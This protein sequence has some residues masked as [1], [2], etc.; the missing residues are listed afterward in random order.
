[1]HFPHVCRSSFARRGRYSSRRLKELGY[2]KFKVVSQVTR[3][4]PM[5]AVTEP[6]FRL[7]RRARKLVTR[8]DWRLR[9]NYAEG[10]WRF[11]YFSSGPSGER[12]AEQWH[13]SETALATWNRLHDLDLKHHTGGM[14]SEDWHIFMLRFDVQRGIQVERKIQTLDPIAHT[15][16]R[17]R[18]RNRLLCRSRMGG[19]SL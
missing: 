6:N 9:G 19:C 4:Q 11:P 12:T 15:S 17:K 16:P 3:A 10:G 2:R 8:V 5:L 1:M 18:R 7:P 14:G 13:D